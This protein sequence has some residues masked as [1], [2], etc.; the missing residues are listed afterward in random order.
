MELTTEQK[1]EIG[2][3]IGT[4][5]KYR[6]TYNELY[7]H[8]LNS[9]ENNNVNYSIN[10]VDRIVN[11]DFGGFSEIVR[12]E[13]LYQAE[14]SKKYN[15]HFRQEMLNTF[16]WPRILTNL[17]VLVFCLFIY[18]SNDGAT[19]NMKP[20]VVGIIIC[21]FGIAIFGFS[22]IIRNK[23][24]YSKYSILDNYF[25]YSCSFGVVM[26]NAVIH[27]LKKDNIWGISPNT[28]FM[29]LLFLF[30]FVSVYLRAF[31]KF[32]NTKYRILAI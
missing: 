19:Y 17:C 11:S 16:K 5:P 13:K 7:D 1:A 32:Y 26:L 27:S 21:V 22:K 14:L 29:L 25:G 20:M 30:F 12:Q 9:F 2:S 23:F 10:E 18:Y 15:K 8:I 4:V 28:S 3:Y 6:E 24:K 31:F